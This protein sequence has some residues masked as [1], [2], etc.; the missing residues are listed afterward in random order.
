MAEVDTD[1]K[2]KLLNLTTEAV[3]Q[4]LLQSAHYDFRA[5]PECSPFQTSRAQF[6]Q[7][8]KKPTKRDEPAE[9]QLAQS[10][11]VRVLFR[12]IGFLY[13]ELATQHRETQELHNL[14][15]KLTVSENREQCPWW[16]RAVD[17]WWAEEPPMDSEHG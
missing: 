2:S 8:D 14:L 16:A 9:S 5:T 3:R 15:R 13:E 4:R 1:V 11:E 10:I 12:T 6:T 7:P 17:S